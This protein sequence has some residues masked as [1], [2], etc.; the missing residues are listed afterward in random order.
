MVDE[1]VRQ[2]VGEVLVGVAIGLE[3]CL[4]DCVAIQGGDESLQQIQLCVVHLVYGVVV[5]PGQNPD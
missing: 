3:V 1:Q 5:E 4:G 2:V